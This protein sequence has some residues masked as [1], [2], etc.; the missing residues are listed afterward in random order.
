MNP[1]IEFCLSNLSSGG[2]EAM[3]ILEQDPD[4]DIVEYGCLDHC[5]ICDEGLFALVNG[6]VVKGTSP[7]DLVRAIYQY[8]EENPMF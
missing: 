7:E 1:I 8:I 6:D 4:L 3:E 5:G 2:Y